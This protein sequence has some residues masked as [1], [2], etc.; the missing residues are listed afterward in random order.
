ME[1]GQRSVL[2]QLLFLWAAVS[3]N[4]GAFF[5]VAETVWNYYRKSVA[6]QEYALDR[7]SFHVLKLSYTV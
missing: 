7:K 4:C 6:K 1:V 3:S 2:G 5:N